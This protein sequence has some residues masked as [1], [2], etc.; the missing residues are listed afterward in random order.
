MH[1]SRSPEAKEAT[2]AEEAGDRD[3]RLRLTTEGPVAGGAALARG[4]GG[5]V[6]FVDG[7]LPG[8]QVEVRLTDERRDFARATV[9]RV[10]RPSDDRVEPPCPNVERRCGGCD[11][12]HVRPAA[13]PLLKRAILADALRRQ[14]HLDDPLI[15]LGPS[16]PAMGFRTSV[17]C[18][19]VDGA[20]GF[21]I[22]ASHDVLDIDHCLVAHPVIDDL[23]HRGRF[24]GADEVTFRIGAA[25]G[26]L[27][28]LAHPDADEIVLPDGVEA[29]V[30]GRAGLDRGSRAWIHDVVA[31]HRFRI[32]A[33]S[34]FQSRAD[35]ATVLVETVIDLGGD[36]L[37]GARTVVDAYAGVGL[38]AALAAPA[39]A[40]VIAV[41]SSRSSVADAQLNLRGRNARIVRSAVERWR[42][43]AAD[44]VIADPPRSGLGRVAVDALVATAASTIIVVSCDAAAFGRD[45]KLLGTHGYRLE[46]SI[47]VDLFPHTHHVEVVSRFTRTRT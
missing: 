5:R 1:A 40:K 36:E 31:G 22:G 34:F 15:E 25:T 8:E 28:V 39:R 47:L 41:E 24:D 20:A 17:R 12:Q 42:P 13:Q 23:I 10:L 11:L 32:S 6:V 38:F 2:E 33:L 14:A 46:R 30:V 4:P 44:V 7:A 9:T 29:I 37:R 26:E 35:A 21:R 16:L 45:A 18:A 19:V 27:L 43:S 3:G